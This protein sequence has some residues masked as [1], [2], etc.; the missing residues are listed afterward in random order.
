MVERVGCEVGWRGNE[1]LE[2]PKMTFRNNIS[3]WPGRAQEA[4]G[5]ENKKSNEMEEDCAA[6]FL[7]L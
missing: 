3:N 2:N 1:E 7:L 4:F 5:K 6:Y